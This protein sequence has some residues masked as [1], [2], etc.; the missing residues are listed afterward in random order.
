MDAPDLVAYRHWTFSNDSVDTTCVSYMMVRKLD[1]VKGRA[2]DFDA[3][4]PVQQ[5]YERAFREVTPSVKETRFRQSLREEARK[6]KVEESRLERIA[7]LERQL[8]DMSQ[9]I[10]RC[11][12]VM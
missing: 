1:K 5:V 10:V 8:A 2:R 6:R 11:N 3:P 9:I 12:E 4:P 7:E